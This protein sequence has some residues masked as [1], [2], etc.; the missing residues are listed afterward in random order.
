MIIFGKNVVKEAIFVKRPIFNLYLDKKFNDDK[1]LQFLTD[2][3]IKFE[4]KKRRTQ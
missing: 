2:K 1:F 4:Q 3:K